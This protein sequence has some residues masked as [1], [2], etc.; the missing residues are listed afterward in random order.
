MR[1][2]LRRRRAELPEADQAAAAMAVLAR[3]ARL[4]VLL[5]ARTVAGYRAIRGE[6]DI[7]AVLGLLL[8]RGVRGTVPRV[9]GADMAFVSWTPDTDTVAGSFGI[10]EPVGGDPVAFEDHDAV[11]VP[12]VAFDRAGNR[13]GQGGGFYDRAIGTAERRPVLIGVA[14]AFQEVETVP[15]EAWDQSLDLVVTEEGLHAF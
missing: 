12:L 9:E 11:L 3:L 15:V 2:L 1:R 7:D 4:D 13:L 5:D 14:H 6:V 10:A 8:D